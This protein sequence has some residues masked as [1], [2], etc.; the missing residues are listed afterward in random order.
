MS[1]TDTAAQARD[2]SAD[3]R[4]P[5]AIATV[6]QDA[7]AAAAVDAAATPAAA[8]EPKAEGSASP[9]RKKQ[10][11][12]TPLLPQK[13]AGTHKEGE[14]KLNFAQRLMELLEKE[15]VRPILHWMEDGRRI[16]IEDPVK[17]AEEVM[18]K[19][20]SDT[21]YKS[22]MVRMKRWGFKTVTPKRT[23]GP[24]KILECELFRRDR[25]DFCLLMGDE[26]RVDRINVA[27]SLTTKV[28]EQPESKPA[29]SAAR[30]SFIP[31][32]EGLLSSEYAAM[33]HQLELQNIARYQMLGRFHD[34]IS[35]TRSVFGAGLR[36]LGSS[37]YGGGGGGTD[38]LAALSSGSYADRAESVANMNFYQIEREIQFCLEAIATQKDR[39]AMLRSIKEMKMSIGMNRPGSGEAGAASTAGYNS[40]LSQN[41]LR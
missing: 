40:L 33:Q 24:A 1:T 29:P 27:K 14:G 23:V 35:P 41:N 5:E 21:K 28:D 18:P 6:V 36:G 12:Y 34:G 10:K 2:T 25:P 31:D 30:S 19:Y 7:P 17:F 39:L 20:F 11:M 37:L 15:D 4:S 26:R 16:C 22:F 8:P 9:V 3:V 32:S 38:P 13:N